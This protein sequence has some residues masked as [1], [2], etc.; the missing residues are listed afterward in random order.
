MRAHA[1]AAAESPK[2]GSRTSFRPTATATGASAA[3][4]GKPR[5]QF[6]F[7]GQ[8]CVIALAACLRCGPSSFSRLKNSS[9]LID[10][11]AAPPD[12]AP[13]PPAASRSKL[14]RHIGIDGREL[15]AQ[16]DLVAIILQALAIHLALHFGR[17]LQR[18]FHRAE[19]H[20]QIL[21]A[22]V[23]DA[24]R[25]GN[26][27]DRRRPSAPAGRPPARASRP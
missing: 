20:D 14:D 17:V 4:C 12:P 6:R 5:R 13:A 18:G 25:A 22:L 24:G 23:A 8:R 27:V 7:V 21:R 10:A 9:F 19:A 1:R 11:L 15:L 2:H 26:I 3:H 16:Q